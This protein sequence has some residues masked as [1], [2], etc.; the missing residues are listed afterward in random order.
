VITVVAAVI[1]RDGHF[2]VTRRLQ[3]VHLAGMW[4]FPGGKVDPG[5]SHVDALAREIAEELGVRIDVRDLVLQTTHAYK[6]VEVTLYFYACD[7]LG[8]PTAL[9]GQE[10]RWVSRHELS[11][12]RFP[13]AD[14][15]LINR[16]TG[17]PGFPVRA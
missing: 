17:R 5:E 13:E 3:G 14:A 7:L 6:D 15:E 9:L 8:E 11:D 10:M 4:E 2:L 12:L 1:E 16:L